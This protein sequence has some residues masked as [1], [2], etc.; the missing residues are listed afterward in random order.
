MFTEAL[1]HAK[2]QYQEKGSRKI[3]HFLDILWQPVF[4][5]ADNHLQ[6]PCNYEV[7]KEK[8][9]WLVCGWPAV[10][11]KRKGVHS[12][13]LGAS[14]PS[15]RLGVTLSK[16]IDCWCSVAK[17]CL[18]LCNPWTAARQASLSFTTSLSLLKL[19]LSQWCY[20]TILSFVVPFFSCLQSFP[21]S[22][23]FL[24]NHFFASGGQSIGAPALASFL[25]MNN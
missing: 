1:L 14:S 5:S 18:T 22:G 6:S 16:S 24:I 17:S 25:L 15:P 2:E 20:P 4:I 23:S 21:G 13:V 7:L 9:T 19:H 11:S 10:S 3:Y 8:N 12:V